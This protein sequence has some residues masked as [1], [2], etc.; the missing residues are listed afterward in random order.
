MMQVTAKDAKIIDKR[1]SGINT[2]I[3]NAKLESIFPI[4]H[5][6]GY[7]FF[8]LKEKSAD[9]RIISTITTVTKK[10]IGLI[11]D[12][13]RKEAFRIIRSLWSFT[14]FLIETIA[15]QRIAK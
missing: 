10:I 2:R 14:S 8:F 5:N 4:I 12:R 1:S 7:I 11:C 3:S 13:D 6:L 15:S 9:I